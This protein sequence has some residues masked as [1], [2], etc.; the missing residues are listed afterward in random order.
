MKIVLRALGVLFVAVGLFCLGNGDRIAPRAAQRCNGRLRIGHR[1][2]RS[3]TRLVRME[4]TARARL[5]LERPKIPS[6]GS[7]EILVRKTGW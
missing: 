2:R 1:S 5:R 6:L 7:L 3:R 4:V